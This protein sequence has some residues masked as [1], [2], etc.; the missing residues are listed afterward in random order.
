VKRRAGIAR[1]I[2][3]DVFT[4]HPLRNAWN[5]ISFGANKNG[6]YGATLDDPMHFNESGLFDGV[7]KAFYGCFT[8]KE[9]NKFEE[10]TRSL[11]LNSRSSVRSDYPKSRISKGFT[12]CTLKTANETVGSLVSVVLAVQDNKVFDMMEQVGGRQQQRYLT[13]PVTVSS[14]PKESGSK[15]TKT[16]KLVATGTKLLD[17]FPARRNYTFGRDRTSDAKKKDFPCTNES[18]RLLFK[19]LKGHGLG[20]VLDLELDEIQMEYLLVVSWK[21][22]S[23]ITFSNQFHPNECLQNII[24]E[25]PFPK[26]GFKKRMEKYYKGHLHRK[27]TLRS[28]KRGGAVTLTPVDILK[29]TNHQEENNESEDTEDNAEEENPKKKRKVTHHAKKEALQTGPVATTISFP[30]LRSGKGCWHAFVG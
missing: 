29:Y 21:A 1:E 6:I 19:H 7:T 20:F 28:T 13:F 18:C 9:L 3:G 16:S 8:D 15:I 12:N 10:T 24:P 4:M 2:L 25:F 23:G 22:F 30:G 26:S 11:H 5:P 17:R 14:T 27:D